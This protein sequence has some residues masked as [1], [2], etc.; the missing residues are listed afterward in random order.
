MRY[1]KPEMEVIRF[2][3]NDIVAAS[4]YVPGTKTMMLSNFNDGIK[5]NGII[6][7]NGT[8][9]VINN[10]N[11]GNAPGMA[12]RNAIDGL[13]SQY[14]GLYDSDRT[15]FKNGN[16]KITMYTLG[17]A[18]S[19]GTGYN[20]DINGIFEYDSSLAGFIRKQ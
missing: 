1:Q 18:E 9:Y 20:V 17:S 5:S 10:T 12:A 2:E 19:D 6:N 11:A 13:N 15:Q 16:T 3:C 4:G 7:Y 8:D 14:F